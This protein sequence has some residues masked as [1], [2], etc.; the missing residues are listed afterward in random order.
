VERHLQASG[1]TW[2]KCFSWYPDI[3]DECPVCPTLG[4]GYRSHL[5]HYFGRNVPQGGAMT[6][7]TE[8]YTTFEERT[9]I[10]RDGDPER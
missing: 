1:G 7:L 9:L 6:D 5:S 8:A 3:V 10:D 4:T 2:R